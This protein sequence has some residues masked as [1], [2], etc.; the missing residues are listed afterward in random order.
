MTD[1]DEV[2]LRIEAAPEKV[3]DLLAD[4]T[5]MPEWSPD[6]WRCSW[7]GKVRE[8][9]AGARFIGFNKTGFPTPNVIES[10][11]RGREF[12]FRTTAHDT[13]WRY[14]LTPDG[15]GTVVTEQRDTSK[16][17][18][19]VVNTLNRLA[20]GEEKLAASFRGG[21]EKTLQRLKATAEA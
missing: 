1:V 6:L 3:W 21:M 13:V 8:P 12:S 10:A 2:S 16:S 5:R 11:E 18:K 4:I 14:L 9:V 15:D 19:F 20:G 7:R 17:K